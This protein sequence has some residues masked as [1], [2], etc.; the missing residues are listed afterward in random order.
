MKGQPITSDLRPSK[1]KRVLNHIFLILICTNF[2]W[3]AEA[4][5]GITFVDL[6][7]GQKISINRN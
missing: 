5:V 7:T 6:K 4:R 3:S 2:F 1:R